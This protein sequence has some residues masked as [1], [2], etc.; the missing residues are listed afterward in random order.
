[1]LMRE[2]SAGWQFWVACVLIIL[3]GC[4][5]PQ[6][7]PTPA[8]PTLSPVTQ[9]AQK[10]ER[11]D[12]AG[13]AADYARLGTAPDSPEAAHFK[14]QAALL[15][16]DLD[17][18][19]EAPTRIAPADRD[20][21]GLFLG[22]QAL[23]A[24]DVGGAL[25]T[26]LPLRTAGFDPYQRG[27]YLRTLGR[28]QLA[29]REP[30]A[31]AA[32]LTRAERYPLPANR[33]AEL[34]HLIW[35]ALREVDPQGLKD[36]LKHDAPNAAGWLALLEFAG[37]RPL[38]A[39]DV[40]TRLADWQGRYPGHPAQIVLV[41][42][43]L[44][45]AEEAPRGVTPHRIAL[46]LPFNG[47]LAAVAD[48]IRDG[49]VAARFEQPG[50]GQA[51]DIV[52]YHTTAATVG[53]VFD[54]AV[55]DGAQFVVGPLEKP[56]VDVLRARQELPVP[57]LALNTTDGAVDAGPQF[58][59]FGLKPEDEATDA[60]ER[61]WREGRRR[62]A[63]IVPNT[64]LGT[65]L[66]LAFET[67]WQALGGVVLAT[68]RFNRDVGSF[69]RTVQQVFGLSDSQARANDLRR[70]LRREIAFDAQRRDDIDAVLMAAMPVDARQILPQ[71]RYFGADAVPLY[72]T[73]MLHDGAG[74]ARADRD[75]DGVMFGDIPWSLGVG[76]A[77]L[78][79]AA[80]RYWKLNPAQQRFFAFGVD[81]WRLLPKLAE[82]R[83]Q[84]GTSL[85][86][87]T[88]TLTVDSAGV[89]HRNLVWAQFV[90]GTTRLL[91]PATP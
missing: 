49:L 68:A 86:G 33:R 6:P 56:A 5:Q 27:L 89:V 84:P 18:P 15:F 42:E 54:R 60:A 51:V 50:D 67:R 76:D 25:A 29:K 14:L 37:K 63:V 12:F 26:L 28:A 45:Q 71:F 1:M 17:Q 70:V 73:S 21:A 52:T 62:V 34:T 69:E 57:V 38:D 82:L 43:L 8:L 35:Q 19:A 24:K 44:K 91:D 75:L 36:L 78:R 39:A 7:A 31:S 85:P 72:A 83:A 3:A 40:A 4:S 87:A 81:A 16:L 32:N 65:R 2:A 66:K 41:N 30:D 53:A 22:L 80:R 20:L 74:D 79:E 48:N 23:Q 59:Q 11:G 46:L 9:A 13:A 47:P 10:L 61:A 90:N 77:P 58:F 64:E 55:A 88:G